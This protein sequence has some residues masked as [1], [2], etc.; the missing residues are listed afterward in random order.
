MISGKTII[1]EE[2]FVDITKIALAKVD[3]VFTGSGQKKSLASIARIVAD[4]VI[5]QITVKKVD[6]DENEGI[7]A[8]V[9]FELKVNI[10]YGQNIPNAISNVRKAVKAEVESITGYTVEKIDVTVEKI[11]K[12]EA[13]EPDDIIDDST[14]EPE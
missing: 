1:S 14:G 13:V 11:V 10:L 4:R 5:P 2:V 8:T 3:S 12:A 9:A 6:A 7:A